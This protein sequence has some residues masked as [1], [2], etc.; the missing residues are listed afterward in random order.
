MKK[1]VVSPR[2]SFS[3]SHSSL[4][5]FSGP[6]PSLSSSF[7]YIHPFPDVHNHRNAEFLTP[8]FINV[9][10]LSFPQTRYLCILAPHM[11]LDPALLWG[12]LTQILLQTLIDLGELLQ[13]PL[14]L[15]CPSP[16]AF[17]C[18][19]FCTIMQVN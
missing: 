10:S 4:D 16:Q 8:S 11:S 14:Q 13:L 17:S 1:K 2:L 18:F 6:L 9:V 19:C 7:T 12:W 3:G 15:P 5:P